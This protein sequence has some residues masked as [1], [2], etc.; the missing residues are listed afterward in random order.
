MLPNLYQHVTIVSE[1]RTS[2][3]WPAPG[4]DLCRLVS[5]CENFVRTATVAPAGKCC[6]SSLR[7]Q[8]EAGFAREIFCCAEQVSFRL[9]AGWLRRGLLI[10][11]SQ[12]GTCATTR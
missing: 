1:I 3:E 11:T 6:N 4:D 5:L 2:R 8:S 9:L 7:V 10:R 12:R